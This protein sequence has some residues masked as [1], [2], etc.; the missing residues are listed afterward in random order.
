MQKL[1]KD[2]RIADLGGFPGPLIGLFQQRLQLGARVGELLDFLRLVQDVHDQSTED[3]D[4]ED[5]DEDED[6]HVDL[7]V[8]RG[9]IAPLYIPR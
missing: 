6:V 2:V 5:A 8:I 4:D 3:E 1:L 9:L 7:Q